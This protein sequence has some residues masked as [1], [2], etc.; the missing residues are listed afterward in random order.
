M[1]RPAIILVNLGTPDK[2]DAP[3]VRRFLK[4]FLW[5]DRVI[6]RRLIWW[7][8]L[9]VIILNIRP[10]KVAEAYAQIW[11]GDSPMRI[12]SQQQAKKLQEKLGDDV[13]VHWAM[14]YGS[15]S[16]K[17]CLALLAESG[18]DKML[19]LPLYPQYSATTTGAIYDIVASYVKSTRN[20]PDIRVLKDYHAHTLYIDALAQSITTHWDNHGKPD[21]LLLSYH[22][23]PQE[24]VDKGDPYQK[25]CLATSQALVEQLNL[26]ETDY[27]VTFQSRFGPTQWIKP[28]TDETLKNIGQNNVKKIDVICPAFSADCLETLEEIEVENREYFLQAGGEEYRYIA[29][30]NDSDAH[31]KLMAE[32]VKENRFF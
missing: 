5:D 1:S 29:A 30:L 4:E 8:I 2:P 15:N 21:Q 19:V 13:Q 26:K 18:V 7:L 6:K 14:T 3:S 31:I 32:L 12:I 11:K 9:N 17:D 25:H 16:L 24:Y 23:I 28:Y 27:T 20:I 10:K 22:G